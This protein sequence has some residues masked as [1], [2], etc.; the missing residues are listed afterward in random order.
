MKEVQG[1]LWKKPKS[2]TIVAGFPGFGLVS[3]IA[4]G[5]II[6]HLKCEQIGKFWFEDLVPTLA[7]HNC[8]LVDPI[9]VHYNKEY[10]LVIV[11]SIAPIQGNEWRAADLII[12]IAKELKA[13]EVLTTEGVG[14]TE[15]Q[16][17]KGF[18]YT[19]NPAHRK[20]FE[21]IGVD[22]LGEGIIVGVTCALLLKAP[23]EKIDVCSLF[24]ETHSN[25]PDAKA[26]AK[27]IELLDKYLGLEIDYAPLLKQAQEFE[28]KLKGI[29]EQAQKA[30]AAKFKKDI[31][32]VG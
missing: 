18:F 10:N 4:T 2:P 14:S 31:S 19:S 24:A 32:Y 15:S 20:R 3:T 13:K 8:S 25:L 9:S 11:H 1:K 22:C 30:K 21:K 28:Q 7:V 5:F 26:A 23:S 27:I 12:K 17:T 6:D 16:D 29:L